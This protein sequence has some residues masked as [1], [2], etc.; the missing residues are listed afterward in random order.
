M[1]HRDDFIF[2]GSRCVLEARLELKTTVVGHGASDAREGRVLI[3]R[4]PVDWW[5][6]E[7]DQRH[8]ELI[9]Q[10]LNLTNSNPVSTPRSLP[11]DKDKVSEYRKLVARASYMAQDR[12][13]R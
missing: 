11:L 3:I 12:A 13:D 2:S 10:E 4:A 5:E 9:V 7:G 8:A 1:V 6:Y